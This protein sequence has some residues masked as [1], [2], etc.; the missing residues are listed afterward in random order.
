MSSQINA[1]PIVNIV[2]VNWNTGNH[3]RE[4]LTAVS[5]SQR[6]GYRLG[7]V[8]VVDNAS[9]DHSAENLQFSK[10]PLTVVHNAINRGFAAASNQGAALCTGDYLL[11]L[12]PDTRVYPDT[13]AKSVHM[14]ESPEC[15]RIGIFGVQLIDENGEVSRDC[16]RFLAPRHF[17]HAMLGLNRVS[18]SRFPGNLYRDFDH[19]RSRIIEHVMGSY[20]FVR[21]DLFQKLGAF[22]ERFF[23]YYEDVDFSLRALREGWTTFFFVGAKCYHRGG[24]SSRQIKARRLFYELRSRIFYAYKHFGFVKASAL[25]LATL[26]IEPATRLIHGMLRASFE[27]IRA[28][29]TGYFLLWKDL[30][31][32]LGSQFLRKTKV[33]NLKSVEE[34]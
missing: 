1:L 28:V 23:V 27:E 26:F 11:F 21:L 13:L 33:V 29:L 25:L 34:M 19:L 4:C 2:I 7:R 30:P 6:E 15:S 16:S 5:V 12:N 10:L 20:F 9:H 32:I 31:S 18:P 14:M 22:D 24:G 17:M 3:L 8:I